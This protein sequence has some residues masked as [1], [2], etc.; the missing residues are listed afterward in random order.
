MTAGE[1]LT[2]DDTVRRCSDCRTALRR[3]RLMLQQNLRGLQADLRYGSAEAK[4]SWI[5]GRYPSE[6]TVVA[7]IC[8]GC[9]RILLY[10]EPVSP[11]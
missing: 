3:I 1:L 6:G 4:A 7:W 8:P 10:G 5:T 2:D 9:G 11:P